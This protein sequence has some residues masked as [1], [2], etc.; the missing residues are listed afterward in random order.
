[1]LRRGSAEGESAEEE[2]AERGVLRRGSAEEE[3]AE[4]E[5]LRRGSAEREVLRRGSAKGSGG[6]LVIS[7]ALGCPQGTARIQLRCRAVSATVLIRGS[8]FVFVFPFGGFGSVSQ[9]VPQIRNR[10]PKIG[11]KEVKMKLKIKINTKPELNKN[12]LPE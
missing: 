3:S 6:V 7:H 1:M 8:V 4:R 5:V 11:P 10:G 12:R 2:S 9:T